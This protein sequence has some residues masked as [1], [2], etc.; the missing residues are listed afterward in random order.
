MNDTA[1][2]LE[3]DTDTGEVMNSVVEYAPQGRE[4]R[5]D[6]ASTT[7]LVLD[8]ESMDKM[9]RMAEFMSRGV[10][11]VP[12][13]LRDNPSDCLAVI[14][15]AMQWKM[16]PFAVAQ[17][18]HIVNGALGYE[19]Q[20]VNAVVKASNAID[21]HFHYQF[22]G[23]GQNVS[24]RV[25]A[26]LRGEKEI[27]W[28]EW[29]NASD[30]TVKNSPLWKTNVKQQLGY[31]QIKNFSRLYCPGAILGIY[32]EDELETIEPRERDVTP[33]KTEPAP[34]ETYPQDKFEKNL[35]TWQ[36]LIET[37]KKSVD[38]IIATIETKGVLSD[39]QKAT[40][41]NIKPGE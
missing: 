35:P 11:T 21:G 28:G 5:L 26:V 4:L 30:V 14:M 31:L 18:T 2:K 27:T 3:I 34:L 20:L 7:S 41:H 40:L 37:G 12:K 19:A 22:Q 13:H 38:Q 39:E 33:K 15:Q 16:N 9:M 6:H 1:E 8:T 36:K 17:K 25:G 23:E 29:L 10:S 32:S 24:C